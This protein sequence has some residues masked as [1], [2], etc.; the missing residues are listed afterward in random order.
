[1]EIC[2]GRCLMPVHEAIY[3]RLIEVAKDGK[4][5]YYSEIAPLAGLNMSWEVDRFKIAQILDDINQLELGRDPNSPML[6]AVVILAEKNI[7]GAGFF[8]C[9]KGLGKYDGSVNEKNRLTFWINELKAVHQYWR[10]HS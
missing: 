3:E 9:A 5:T 4:F 7:P 10:S 1:M 2:T 6:S 8:E